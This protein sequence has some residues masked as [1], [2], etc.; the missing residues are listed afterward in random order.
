M[1]KVKLIRK[2]LLILAL[3][4]AILITIG[5]VLSY[6]DGFPLTWIDYFGLICAI[7]MPLFLAHESPRLITFLIDIHQLN[8][9]QHH[10]LEGQEPYLFDTKKILS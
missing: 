3:I 7:A 6:F 4:W 9:E 5:I 10:E 2:I 8:K 1:K